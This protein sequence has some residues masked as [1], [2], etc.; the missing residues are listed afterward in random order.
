MSNLNRVLKKLE[1]GTL[2]IVQETN[3]KGILQ[4]I[5]KEGNLLWRL[6]GYEVKYDKK[7]FEKEPYQVTP[8]IKEITLYK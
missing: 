5:Y 3:N 4:V 7:Y 8:K 6:D 2:D 1:K